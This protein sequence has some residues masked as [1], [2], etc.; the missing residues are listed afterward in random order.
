MIDSTFPKNRDTVLPKSFTPTSDTYLSLRNQYKIRHLERKK[1]DNLTICL[2]AIAKDNEEEFIVFATDHMVTTALGQFE[3]TMVKYKQ[4]NKN[5]VVMLAGN[6]LIFDELVKL[7]NKDIPFQKVKEEIFQNFKTKRKDVIKNEIFDMYG[8]DE[9]F[10]IQSLRSQ[11]LNPLINTILKQISEFKLATGIL[12]IGFDENNKA[13]IT[14]INEENIADFRDMNFHA[15]GSGNIQAAN[16]LLFQKHDKSDK[17]LATVYSVFKAKRNAEV[18][19]GVGKETELLI[20]SKNGCVKIGKEET[21]ILDDI[22]KNELNFGK[23]HTNLSK[24]NITKVL[25]EC[26]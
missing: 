2:A 23:Y 14:E 6:P 4:L 19:Q 24:F 20:L 17:L 10:F 21:D 1:V 25:S 26:S 22:Y 9:S 3:H 18:L 5:T 13:Q 16:T 12:L 7:K 8:I 15:I 11:V